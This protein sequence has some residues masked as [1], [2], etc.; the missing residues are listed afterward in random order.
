MLTRLAFQNE[1]IHVLACDLTH[2]VTH[3]LN[4]ILTHIT[5]ITHLTH[6]THLNYLKYFKVFDLGAPAPVLAIMALEG[7][8]NITPAEAAAA[9][10]RWGGRP[11]GK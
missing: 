11:R 1:H 6:L 9:A 10:G 8:L 3:A 2:T 4:F 5:Q 7:E